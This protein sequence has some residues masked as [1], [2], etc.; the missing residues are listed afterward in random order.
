VRLVPAG[1][2]RPGA[3][4]SVAE[5]MTRSILLAALAALA[6]SRASPPLVAQQAGDPDLGRRADSAYRAQAWE[7]A[8]AAYDSLA[9]LTPTDSRAWFRLGTALQALY[10]NAEAVA[11]YRRV[12]GLVPLPVAMVRIA[13]AF[14]NMRVPD[15]AFAWLFR[16][17][18]AGLRTDAG[19]ADD[20]TFAS[21]RADTR[22][23]EFRHRLEVAAHPCAFRAESRQF[24]FWLGVWDV[25]DQ[26]GRPVGESRIDSTLGGCALI[27]H[28]MGAQGDQGSSV[29]TW[30]PVTGAW[31]QTWLD[32]RGG[33]VEYVNGARHADTL[34]FPRSR[35]LADGA[36]QR[37]TFIADSPDQV[38]Q[39]GERSTDGGKTWT[40]RYDFRYARKH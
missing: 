28:W 38:R 22:Y 14:A 26:S 30:N 21:L 4:D 2:C 18:D 25:R 27:E 36:L 40:V 15:S 7:L 17:A 16:A 29:N 19:I 24:D 5:P 37:L 1:C 12:L 35:P 10:R 11:A 31:Q 34:T 3:G 20:P 9:R 6:I 33:V 32:D 8:A 13:A 23:G 39:I